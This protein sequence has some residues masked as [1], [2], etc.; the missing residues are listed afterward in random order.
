[1]ATKM[2]KYNNG[3][4]ANSQLRPV[5]DKTTKQA[6]KYRIGGAIKKKKYGVGGPTTKSNS[7]P[8]EQS[9]EPNTPPIGSNK[10]TGNPRFKTGGMVN[11]NAKLVADK[12]PGSK[13]VKSGVNSKIKAST[14][15]KGKTGGT[16]KSVAKPKKG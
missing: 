9:S 1:M 8:M 3:G 16:N 14:K 12:T 6:S 15:A 10:L 2:K 4:A 7:T 13:G 11:T 5:D